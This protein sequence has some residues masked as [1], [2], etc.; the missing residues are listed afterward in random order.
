M[1]LCPEHALQLNHRKNQEAIR[2]QRKALRRQER[3]GRA[4]D[5]GDGAGSASTPGTIRKRQRSGRQ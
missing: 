4:S 3:S 2:A 1:R 5:T